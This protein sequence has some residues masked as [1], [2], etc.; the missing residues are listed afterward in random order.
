MKHQQPRDSA[1]GTA[2]QSPRWEGPAGSKP[3]GYRPAQDGGENIDHPRK[4]RV[5]DALKQKGDD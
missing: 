4:R 1:P 3:A 2:E 5:S